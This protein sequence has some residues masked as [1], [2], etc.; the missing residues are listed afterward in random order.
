[1]AWVQIVLFILGSLAFIAW[2]IYQI[3]L[4]SREAKLKG[5]RKNPPRFKNFA[6][7]D[8]TNGYFEGIIVRELPR[9]NGCHLIEFLPTD[10]E[11]Q[12]GKKNPSIQSVVI[13]KDNLKRSSRG[14]ISGET[15]QIWAMP[16]NDTEIPKELRKTFIGDLMEK[17]SQY[18]FLEKTFGARLKETLRAA[19]QMIKDTTEVGLT[20]THLATLKERVK[21]LE[22]MLPQTAVNPPEGKD[23][24]E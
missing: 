18:A 20:A 15:E 10:I 21:E 5:I 2:L 16:G 19:N 23:K 22:K 13:H 3:V 17:Q 24:K 14:G 6:R 11:R 9:K 8:F 1:M 12:E 7:T 4:S